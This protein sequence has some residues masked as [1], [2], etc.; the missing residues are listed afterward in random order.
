MDPFAKTLLR[1]F[2]KLLL[3]IGAVAFTMLAL[4]WLSLL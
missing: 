3:A 2:G 4:H 1:G